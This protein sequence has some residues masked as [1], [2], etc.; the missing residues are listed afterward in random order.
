MEVK[1]SAVEEAL[2]RKESMVREG[3]VTSDKMNKTIVVEVT[4]TMQHT[5]FKK[6]IKRRVRYTVHDEKN[7][8]KSGNR[9]Q[10]QE[11]K[12]LSKTKRWKL[13]KVISQ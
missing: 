4:R 2:P 12:P 8:A 1:K 10:I 7:E 11:T 13:V 5:Q 3:V 6:I 9:V